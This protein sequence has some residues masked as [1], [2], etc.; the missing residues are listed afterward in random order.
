M[1][2]NPISRHLFHLLWS[3]LITTLVALGAVTFT[4]C[5]KTPAFILDAQDAVTGV[6]YRRDPVEVLRTSQSGDRRAKALGS[7]SEPKQSNGSQKEQDEAV[8]LLISAA[9]SDPAPICRLR[10]IQTMGNYE[11]PRVIEG[12]KTAYYQATNFPPEINNLIRQRVLESLGKTKNPAARDL[13]I[14]VARADAKEKDAYNQKLTT[15]ERLAAVRALK[16][17][18]QSDAT[19]TLLHIL[20]T[21]RD[22]GLRERAHESLVAATG[23]SLPPDPGAWEQVLYPSNTPT[24]N[25]QS[26]VRRVG[27]WGR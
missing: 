14:R 25:P 5:Q 1:N 26:P 11:D 27:G 22:V 19:D 23:K 15:D 6:V 17:F 10:A 18:K 20:K 9:T 7:L 3:G 8:Y 21:E 16:N 24:G 4:G 13:L 2:A 12:L